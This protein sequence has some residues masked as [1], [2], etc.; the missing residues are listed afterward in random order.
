MQLHPPRQ[1]VVEVPQE[2]HRRASPDVATPADRHDVERLV[3][4]AVVVEHGRR[5]AID[6]VLA[7]GWRHVASFHC[8]PQRAACFS[9]CAC[10]RPRTGHAERG[11]RV[12]AA[13]LCFAVGAM[14]RPNPPA[15]HHRTP[16]LKYTASFSTVSMRG[17]RVSPC[18]IFSKVRL[19]TP[20]SRDNAGHW[21]LRFWS[22]S[23]TKDRVSFMRR[24]VIPFMGFAQPAFGI[25]SSRQL[26]GI[27]PHGK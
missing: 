17:L 24:S 7:R 19:L 1:Y 13:N 27:S 11:N 18:A 12:A 4:V 14:P 3:V 8:G 2:R 15:L 6:A 23:T 21:P 26:R 25:F 20:D 16:R 22:S 10:R 5:A 9:A